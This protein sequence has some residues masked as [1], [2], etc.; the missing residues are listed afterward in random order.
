MTMA[1]LFLGLTLLFSVYGGAI[2]SSSETVVLKLI[3]TISK[4]VNISFD[5]ETINL[6]DMKQPTIIDFSI[7]AN[8]EYKVL[9]PESGILTNSS[10]DTIGFT[11]QIKDGKLTITPDN[12]GPDHILGKYSTNLPITISAI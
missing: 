10:G 7:L 9:V 8:T 12:I 2:A 4:S 1:K 6:G 3:G 5:D 11:T